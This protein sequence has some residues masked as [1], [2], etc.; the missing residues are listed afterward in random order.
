MT[1][2]KKEKYT[3]IPNY[4]DICLTRREAQCLAF[5]LKGYSIN[6]ISKVVKL[7]SRTINFYLVDTMKK[8][9]CNSMRELLQKINKTNFSKY[10][11]DLIKTKE[12]LLSD[13]D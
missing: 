12:R 8:F 6:E 5:V 1:K 7:S 3:L 4:P 11:D 13:G 2:K 9:H 10:I